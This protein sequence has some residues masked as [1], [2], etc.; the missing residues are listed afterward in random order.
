MAVVNSNAAAPSLSYKLVKSWTFILIVEDMSSS[1]TL[2]TI[3]G[4]LY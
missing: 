4:T 1:G 3:I 2:R